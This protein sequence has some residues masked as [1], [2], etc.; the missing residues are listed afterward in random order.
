MPGSKGLILGLP[1][2]GIM[3]L[4]DWGT[5]SVERIL[6]K[7]TDGV[8]E[9]GQELYL[10]IGR[11]LSRYRHD[12]EYIWERDWD[13][14]VVL[15]ACRLDLMR[16]VA[17][18]YDF[19]NRVQ[20][21]ESVGSSTREWLDGNFSERFD[22]ELSETAYVRA[23]PQSLPVDDER[24]ALLDEVWKY[25]WDNDLGTVRPRK[26][27]DRAVTAARSD[28]RYSKMIVHYMQPH[29]PFITCPHLGGGEQIGIGGDRQGKKRKMVWER[30][31]D[32]EL[33][34]A[35]VWSAYQ[36]NLERVLDDVRV[37]LSNV[38]AERAIVTS[39]HGNAL[40]EFGAYGHRR[41]TPLQCLV[42][43]PWCETTATD[44]GEHK[45]D[46]Q[47]PNAVDISSD[48]VED[49]LAALGYR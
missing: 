48:T 1:Q 7:G 4:L 49:R 9:S 41:A 44:S 18:R 32:G 24:F 47:V 34:R 21:F 11:R 23:N 6:S 43:V 26:V 19:I 13:L 39:D 38:D 28:V 36:E 22:S 27:T 2:P 16:E 33:S 12:P 35:E 14:L 25:A 31:R 46:T 17:P 3:S 30:L 45:P 10:G 5:E 8:Q 40:G 15:D 29:M 20:C 42:E 37:L